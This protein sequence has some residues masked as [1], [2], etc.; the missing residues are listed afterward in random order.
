MTFICPEGAFQ[1]EKNLEIIMINSLEA[2]PLFLHSLSFQ[3]F[4]LSPRHDFTLKTIFQHL[5]VH[6]LQPIHL[7]RGMSVE[8]KLCPE[9]STSSSVRRFLELIA[10][11]FLLLSN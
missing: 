6:H 9:M 2:N 5:S 10:N 3:Q 8:P 1:P 11:S 4:S 7:G